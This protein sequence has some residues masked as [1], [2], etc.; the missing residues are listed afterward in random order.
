MIP[1][2][3]LLKELVTSAPKIGVADLSEFLRHYSRF[4]QKE[5]AEEIARTKAMLGFG[6]AR[7]RKQGLTPPAG[8]KA[9]DAIPI[10]LAYVR[11]EKAKAVTLSKEEKGSFAA[12][13]EALDRRFGAGFTKRI[14]EE[15]NA[16]PNGSQ[17]MRYER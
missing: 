4:D 5:L 8:L 2:R 10:V 7:K 13:T 6:A 11:E 1:A 16:M 3:K 9:R 14:V 15:L 17:S 12:M